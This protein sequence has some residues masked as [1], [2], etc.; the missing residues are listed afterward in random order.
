MEPILAP[1]IRFIAA[2][3]TPTKLTGS[4]RRLGTFH[5]RCHVKPGSSADR[6]GVQA[7][8]DKAIAVCVAEVPR[9]GE[10]NGTVRDVIARALKVKQYQVEIV[11]GKTSREKIVAVH[12]MPIETSSKDEVERIRK[13]LLEGVNV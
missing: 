9:D 1:V 10:A 5:L 3:T 8:S 4:A 2:S 11:K 6:T 12:E 7:I 13:T